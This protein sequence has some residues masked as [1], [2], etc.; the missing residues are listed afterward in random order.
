MNSERV[1]KGWVPV[2]GVPALFTVAFVLWY[3]PQLVKVPVCGVKM[4]IGVPCP[5][6]GLV[7][8]FVVLFHGDIVESIYF[9]PMGIVIAGALAYAFVRALARLSGRPLKPLLSDSANR[10][11]L[12]IFIIALLVQ[13]V[14][15]LI[16]S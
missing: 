6:C 2:I 3:F 8:S 11:V 13:W 9:N 12:N 1:F 14:I 10:I 4:M 5:G 7:R 16:L 15:G